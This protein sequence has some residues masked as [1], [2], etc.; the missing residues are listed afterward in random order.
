MS[1]VYI[2]SGVD[3][4]ALWHRG[5]PGREQRA[6]IE[7]RAYVD[8]SHRPVIAI[9]GTQRLSWLH[10]LTTQ[11]LEHLA[12]GVWI[13]ALILDPSGSV[14]H[15]LFIV[16]DE[17]TSWI[18][19]EPGTAQGLIDYLDSMKFMLDVS[20]TNES[21]RM[22]VLRAPG[23][24]D[25]YGGPFALLEK[26]EKD[27]TIEAFASAGAIEAGMWAYEAE[28]IALGRPRLGLETDDRSIPHE[29][30]WITTAVH[31]KKG[32]YRG[33]ETV[34]KVHNLGKPPRRLVLLHLDGSQVDLPAHGDPVLLDGE[35]VGKI[36]S[37]ARHHELGP[38]ALAVI[39]RTVAI[40]AV[41]TAAGVP[42]SQEA[43]VPVD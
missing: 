32:C 19:V 11:H 18:H 20:V 40:D 8:L 10:S 15:Q 35:S 21:E 4:G 38:I 3:A 29:L 16:D 6:L 24:G 13:E 27:A 23:I 30:G 41:L 1:A 7:G 31:L 43:I 34:A 2:E 14:E 9:R 12:P 26:S 39:K 33:Q 36:G 5:D 17:E 42:A 37:V 25:A 28:R 22:C